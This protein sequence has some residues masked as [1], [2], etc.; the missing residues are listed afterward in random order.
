[1]IVMYSVVELNTWM[2]VLRAYASYPGSRGE[3]KKESLVQTVR[4]C[5]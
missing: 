3:R 2:G 4:A 1:M 5:V